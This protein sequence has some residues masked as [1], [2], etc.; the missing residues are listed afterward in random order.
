MFYA[1]PIKKGSSPLGDNPRFSNNIRFFS[2]EI[3]LEQSRERL[4][5]AGFVARHLSKN[6]DIVEKIHSS[7]HH[8]SNKSR[9]SFKKLRTI[10]VHLRRLK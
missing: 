5:V 10:L 8:L 4:A 1:A 3:T 9:T 6:P 2:A 7:F